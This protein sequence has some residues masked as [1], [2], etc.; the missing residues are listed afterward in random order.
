MRSFTKEE[1]DNCILSYG[2]Y[3]MYKKRFSGYGRDYDANVGWS[4]WLRIC[5]MFNHM[6]MQ[7]IID[8]HIFKLPYRLGSLGIVQF[9]RKI[10][11]DSDGNLMTN[12]LTV[13]WDKTLKLWKVLYPQCET[14]EDYKKIRNKQLVFNTNEHT[15]GRTFRFHWKKKYSN[16]PNISAYEMVIATQYKDA[17]GRKIRENNNI[18]YCTKF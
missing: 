1:S 2:L 18:Q 13:D 5:K 9:K 4:Q 15:D 6:K 7:S 16:V 8:G 11:F 17:L 10:R 12:K 3:K 14:R